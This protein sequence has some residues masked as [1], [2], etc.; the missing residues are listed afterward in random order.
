MEST[1]VAGDF[2]L[3]NKFVAGPMAT[4]LGEKMLRMSRIRRG[5]VIVF[6]HP[7]DPGRDAVKRVI[8]MPG[9]TILLENKRVYVQGRLLHEP[10]VLF[11]FAPDAGE[12][13][14]ADPPGPDRPAWR[15]PNDHYFTLGDNRDS[16]EDSRYWG[17]LPLRSVRGKAMLIYFSLDQSPRPKPFLE[18]V[19]WDRLMQ[20]IR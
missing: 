18:R 7:E 15:I 16:S 2:L 12:P 4:S 17:P 6:R 1:L 14:N 5:D 10:Y 11:T 13:W 20:W 19:R 9:E 8:G 3:V